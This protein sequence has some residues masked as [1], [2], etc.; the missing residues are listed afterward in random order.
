ML[1]TGHLRRRHHYLS[2]VA[3]SLCG[4]KVAEIPKKILSGT[5]MGA[6]LKMGHQSAHGE[7]RVR[8]GALV[9]ARQ[10]VPLALHDASVPRK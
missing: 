6:P 9:V 10:A 5:R 3:Q 2:C 8:H 7:A 4:G 1:F